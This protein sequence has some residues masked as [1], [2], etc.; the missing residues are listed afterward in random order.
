MGYSI[1]AF[2]VIASDV[3]IKRFAGEDE[4]SFCRRVAYSAARFWL[5][6]FC[7]DDGAA[8]KK[9]LAKQAMNHR[10]K[11]W[12]SALDRIHP[13]LGE[14]FDA[15]GKGIPAVYNRMIDI[16][17]LVPN[18]FS[19]LYIAMPPSKVALSEGLSCITGYFDP[20][21]DSSRLGADDENPPL[22]SGLAFLVQSRNGPIFRPDS[23]WIRNLE[24]INWEKATDFDSVEFANVHTSRWNINCSDVWR[25]EPLWV[26]DLAVARAGG[27]G[28]EPV[29][30]VATRK[31]GRVRLSK[32]SWIQAQELFFYLKNKGGS[33]V[34]AKY[35]MLD[36]LH[37]QA[38]LP[39]GFVPGHINRILDAIGWPVDDAADRFNRIVRVEALPLVEE[40]LSASYIKF[41]RA[42]N[43]KQQRR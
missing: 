24:Y 27:A 15:G 19:S 3:G 16:G 38:V 21:S 41:E 32:I 4:E 43:G 1:D 17:D 5:L 18:G 11:G 20:T 8:G 26:H 10:L 12:V 35:S 23:W 28:I 40:L 25:D 22:L 33:G 29:V 13:N 39:V 37:A 6:A 14:W 36:A 30:F 2:N 7:M 31:R 42:S 34:V 9:G